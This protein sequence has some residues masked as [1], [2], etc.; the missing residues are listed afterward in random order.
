MIL[1]DIQIRPNRVHFRRHSYMKLP[2]PIQYSNECST[3]FSNIIWQA[4]VK[5]STVTV[6]ILDTVSFTLPT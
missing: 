5:R 1:S 2:S 3:Q 4:A 6:S